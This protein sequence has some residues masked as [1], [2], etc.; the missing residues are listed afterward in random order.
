MKMKKIIFI[1]ALVTHL[2]VLKAQTVELLPQLFSHKI[3]SIVNMWVKKN[4][5]VGAAIGIVDSSKIIYAKGYGYADSANKIKVTDKTIFRVGS[6][7]KSFTALAVMQLYQQGKLDIHKSIK[8]YLP[9]LTISSR[10]NDG[11]EIFIKDILA[12]TSGLPGDVQNGHD[13]LH[14][15]GIWHIV[16]VLNQEGFTRHP[17][18]FVHAYSNEGYDLLGCLIERVSGM[19]YDAYI[20]EKLLDVIGMPMSGIYLTDQ[21]RK[22]YSKAYND[23]G[24]LDEPEFTDIP[25]GLLHSNTTDMCKFMLCLLNNGKNNN[26]PIIDKAELVNMMASKT[27]G[28]ELQ[29]YDGLD[30]G[31]GFIT[32]KI[33]F[34]NS[35]SDRFVGHGG[36]TKSYHCDYFILPKTKIGISIMSNSSNFGGRTNGLM[37]KLISL[38]LKEEKKLSM[39]KSLSTKPIY[40]KQPN[41]KN[42]I[43]KYNGVESM[44]TIKGNARKLRMTQGK[45]HFKLKRT[46]DSTY[47]GYLK[48]ARLIPVKAKGFLVGFEEINAQSYMKMIVKKGVSE[49]YVVKKST[50]VNA[51][52][53]IAWKKD[54]GSYQII[55]LLPGC[56]ENPNKKAKIYMDKA[57]LVLELTQLSKKGKIE[58][59]LT[60]YD[61]ATLETAFSGGIGRS[62]NQVL[63]KLENGNLYSLGFELEKVT[64]TVK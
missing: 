28:L 49:E 7:T 18:S 30:W 51:A 13:C 15:K 34:T 6:I 50:T 22:Q 36:D 23:E 12:H 62:S 39:D 25:A 2:L 38:I 46:K 10:F 52:D 21:M 29:K 43:G 59:I 42:I 55:N 60:Y 33:K 31:Y 16:D 40:S 35:D 53:F 58:K 9:E 20:K 57:N 4:K 17:K 5:G 54:L 37:L 48:L 56:V 11:N 19:K 45:Y 64:D 8:Y 14:P 1:Y 47:Q 27:K 26:T 63:R 44:I 32:Q 3:D 24:I 41:I 61:I